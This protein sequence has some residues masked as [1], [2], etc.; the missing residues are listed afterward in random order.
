MKTL[1]AHLFKI[2]A[3]ISAI[4]GGLLY[5]L[6]RKSKKIDD[7]KATVDLTVQKES[8]KVV[9]EKVNSAQKEIDALSQEMKKPVSD[10][11]WNDYTKD[12]KK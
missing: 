11:F 2:I 4:I 12:K 10:E 5:L 1:K 9:D 7:L 6:S 3:I 8:S